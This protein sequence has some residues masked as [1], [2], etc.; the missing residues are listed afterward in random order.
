MNSF[1]TIP[2]SIQLTY[3]RVSQKE[4]VVIDYAPED[5]FDPLE[6]YRSTEQIAAIGEFTY[7]G[8]PKFISLL[9]D[10]HTVMFARNRK[11]D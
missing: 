4:I 6:G 3:Q 9:D 7:E 5:Y 8:V 1:S 10:M 11:N 2:F